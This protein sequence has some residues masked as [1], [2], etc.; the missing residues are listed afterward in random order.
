MQVTIFCG[1]NISK[2]FPVILFKLTVCF[3]KPLRRSCYLNLH[4]LCEINPIKNNIKT[5]LT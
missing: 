4:A 3:N 2:C 1:I 5:L